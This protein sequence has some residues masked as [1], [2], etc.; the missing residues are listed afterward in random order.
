MKKPYSRYK[1]ICGLLALTS[2]VW[3]S[4][5]FQLNFEKGTAKF[6]FADTPKVIE[7]S[8]EYPKNCANLVK[9][10]LKKNSA[11][12]KQSGQHCPTG[13]IINVTLSKSLS[14]DI[15]HGGGML[16][17]D[18]TQDWYQSFKSITAKSMGGLIQSNVEAISSNNNWGQ[19][20]AHYINQQASSKPSLNMYLMG[21]VIQFI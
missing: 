12:F 2:Q 1:W 20:E 8:I 13:A 19:P 9:V 6:K 5:P 14:Y 10:S 4:E 15:Q 18:Q 3:A 17:F 16:I 7:Y 21:G 11:A